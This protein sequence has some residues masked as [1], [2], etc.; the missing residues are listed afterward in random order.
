V[1]LTVLVVLVVV[2]SDVQLMVGV[3]EG[4]K[5]LHSRVRG[6]LQGWGVRFGETEGYQKTC[7]R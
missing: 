1:G 3:F 6:E 7:L 5:S 4:F 2:L